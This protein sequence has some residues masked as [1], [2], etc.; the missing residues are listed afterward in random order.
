MSW[1]CRHVERASVT[2]TLLETA[3]IYS[4]SWRA[5]DLQTA[6]VRKRLWQFSFPAVPS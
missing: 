1:V 2:T 5:A 3:A 6:A 4:R